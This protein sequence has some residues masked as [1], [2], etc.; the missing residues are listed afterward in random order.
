MK[1]KREVCII[2]RMKVFFYG[3]ST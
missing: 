3:F 2:N 1:A